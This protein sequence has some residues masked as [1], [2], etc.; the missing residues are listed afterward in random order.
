MTARTV[1]LALG[2]LWLL[3]YLASTD[4]CARAIVIMGAMP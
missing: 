1:G 2:C 4:G 3:A